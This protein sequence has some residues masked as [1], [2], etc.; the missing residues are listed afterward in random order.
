MRGLTD[1]LERARIAAG[2]IPLTGTGIV[3]QLGDSV[4]PPAPDDNAEDYLVGARDVRSLVE[5]LWAAIATALPMLSP[6]DCRNYFKAA[7]YGAV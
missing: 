6:S 1:E 4:E 3:L 2:L 7:G 5:E